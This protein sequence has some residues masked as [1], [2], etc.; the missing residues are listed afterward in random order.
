M[1][2]I[3]RAKFHKIKVL[4][5]TDSCVKIKPDG[6]KEE[7]PVVILSPRPKILG[8]SETPK[9]QVE[10]CV[11][12]VNKVSASMIVSFDDLQKAFNALNELRFNCPP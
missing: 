1:I 5:R 12:Q 9:S 8:V 3:Q 6:A 10:I 4:G 11:A 2:E 7:V